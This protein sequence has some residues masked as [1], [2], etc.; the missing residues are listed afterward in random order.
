[1]FRTVIG[2]ILSP[3][4]MFF[5]LGALASVFK[6]DLRFPKGL[7]DTL[8]LYLLIA[9]GL[10]GGM[11]IAHSPLGDIAGPIIAAVAMGITIPIAAYWVTRVL[12]F[13]HAD[14]I[15]LAAAA[16]SVSIV[17]FGASIN[18]LNVSGVYYE[19]FMNAIVVL[20]ESPAIFVA[21]VM[22]RVWDKRHNANDSIISAHL[23]RDTFFGQSVLLL[24]GSLI[25]GAIISQQAMTNVKPLF[26][27]LYRGF[28]VLF[29]LYMGLEAGK[30]L[31]SLR[32][33]LLKLLVVGIG[34]PLGFGIIGVVVGHLVG[35]STGGAMVFGILTGSASYIAAPAAMRS[36][37]PEANPA[38]YIGTALGLTFPFNLAIGIP[39]YY[40][41][42]TLL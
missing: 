34:L 15:A 4:V 30:H 10:K 7:A 19:S 1:M 37:V 14:G 21:L 23:I 24:Q 3:E 26:T 31:R 8:S 20:M 41:I 2:N 38:L 17:T 29:L 27:D 28:L 5:V 32:G 18:Y 6:S 9:I 33:Q 22:Y 36:S 35:L 39:L 16:G 40:W 11:E 12:R 13:K 25:I 42:S